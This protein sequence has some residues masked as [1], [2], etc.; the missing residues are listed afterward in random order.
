MTRRRTRAMVFGGAVVALLV[1]VA[2]PVDA[3]TVNVCLARKVN[4]VGTAVV[5]RARCQAKD[6]TRPDAMRLDRCVATAQARFVDRDDPSRGMFEK[7][8]A[9]SSC[10]TYDDQARFDGAI[11]D[12]VGSLRM[13]VGN[14]GVPSRCDGAKIACVAK[15]V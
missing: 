14:A 6:A 11:G 13:R 9:H 12:Y 2:W 1:A 4:A 15:Y 5:T 10:L 3:T 7:A 8:E